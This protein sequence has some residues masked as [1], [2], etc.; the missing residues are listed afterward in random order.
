MQRASG[1]ELYTR[2]QGPFEIGA[3][4]L[5][6]C[7]AWHRRRCKPARLDCK[8]VQH[9]S[10]RPWG[11]TEPALVLC[12]ARRD[13]EPATKRVLVRR[14]R[15]ASAPAAT[16]GGPTPGPHPKTPPPQPP[17]G[18]YQSPV[19]STRPVF[20]GFFVWLPTNPAGFC[21]DFLLSWRQLPPGG[22]PDT[23]KVCSARA[24][25]QER[26]PTKPSCKGAVTDT[27]RASPRTDRSLNPL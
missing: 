14:A 22:S 25:R 3:E 20:R 19:P 17:R 7:P 21:V 27:Q 26:P 5:A 2:L 8:R 23:P 12:W 6:T 15:T 1:T 24:P 9:R 16:S 18:P 11:P 10:I 13:T 4:V